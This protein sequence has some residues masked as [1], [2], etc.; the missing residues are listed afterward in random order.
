M[1]P[2]LLYLISFNK[3]INTFCLINFVQ[4]IDFDMIKMIIIIGI[5]ADADLV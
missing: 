5:T 4:L 3:F 2:I 1:G